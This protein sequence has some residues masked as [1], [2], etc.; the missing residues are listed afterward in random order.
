MALV[1]LSEGVRLTS[2]CHPLKLFCLLKHFMYF[3]LVI[4]QSVYICGW[5]S[6]NNKNLFELRNGWR[7]QQRLL[8]HPT[9]VNNPLLFAH[10][11]SLHHHWNVLCALHMDRF[12]FRSQFTFPITLPLMEAKGSPP[13]LSSALKKSFKYLVLINFHL[14]CLFHPLSLFLYLFLSLTHSVSCFNLS[15]VW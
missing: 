2:H 11:F 3:T 12:I 8:P 4:C 5:L 1:K 6:T 7:R 13:S 14:V 15:Q 10:S 9:L